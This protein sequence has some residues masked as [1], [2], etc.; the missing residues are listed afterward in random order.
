[1]FRF[2]VFLLFWVKT[3]WERAAEKESIL[4]RKGVTLVGFGFQ[5][6]EEKISNA[7]AAGSAVTTVLKRLS[8]L[9]G[10]AVTVVIRQLLLW[11]KADEVSW[12]I[13]DCWRGHSAFISWIWLKTILGIV[14][15]CWDFSIQWLVISLP[16]RCQVLSTLLVFYQKCFLFWVFVFLVQGSITTH[17]Q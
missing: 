8:Q 9:S 2:K 15:S 16:A 11:A 7:Q 4:A 12:V 5:P 14:A 17:F 6:N 10:K 13:S 3:A 1:M